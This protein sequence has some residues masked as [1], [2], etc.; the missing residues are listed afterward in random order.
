M[1]QLAERDINA[2]RYFVR[3]T[4]FATVLAALADVAA[5]EHEDY[6][7]EALADL[8]RKGTA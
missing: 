4:N 6:L 2:L 3:A 5:E 7:A 1:K 8:A